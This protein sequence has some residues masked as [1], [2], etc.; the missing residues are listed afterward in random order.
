M[1]EL[2]AV[3]IGIYGSRKHR[4]NALRLTGHIDPVAV[5]ELYKVTLICP[6]GT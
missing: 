6:V 3:V 5:I 1:N 2:T 4:I